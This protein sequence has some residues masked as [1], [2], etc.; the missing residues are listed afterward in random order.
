MNTPEIS[1]E[2][3]DDELLESL[4]SDYHED[5]ALGCA[6]RELQRHRSA[7]RQGKCAPKADEPKASTGEEYAWPFNDEPTNGVSNPLP[8]DAEK[9]V[10][11]VKRY[12]VDGH[13]GRLEE[14]DRQDPYHM[15]CYAANPVYVSAE[16]FDRVISYITARAK[17]EPALRE[18]MRTGADAI[19]AAHPSWRPEQAQA[20][21]L[22]D[23]AG[24]K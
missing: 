16:D 15:H 6:L 8:P 21:L 18:A 13:N 17:Q 4:A 20:K 19:R 1:D 23:A 2:F 14:F 12:V 24:E 10:E 9:I 3:P 5:S 22:E 7:A 11:G